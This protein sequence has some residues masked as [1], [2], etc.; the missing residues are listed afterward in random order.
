[1]KAKKT[2][3]PQLADSVGRATDFLGDRWTF[4]ILRE[5]YF[6]TKRFNEFAEALSIS[7]NILSDRLKVLVSNGI[8]TQHP[9]GP[10]GVRYEYRLAQPGRDLYPTILALLQWGDKYLAGPDGPTVLLKHTRCGH[11]A[12]PR[13]VCD[14]CGEQIE[15]GH[16]LPL[17]GPGAPDWLRQRLEELSDSPFADATDA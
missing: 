7:R 2:S 13:L 15:V 14:G 1:M 8:L 6:G 16:V 5:A 3:K 10:S 9:Y 4:L 11:L 12:D 17:P